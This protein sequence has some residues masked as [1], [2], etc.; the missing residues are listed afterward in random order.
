MTNTKKLEKNN[1]EILIKKDWIIND[2][3]QI[4]NNE[5]AVYIALRA[6]SDISFSE[7]TTT[8]QGLYFALARNFNSYNSRVAAF[9]KEGVAEFNKKHSDVVYASSIDK[10]L[11]FSPDALTVDDKKDHYFSVDLKD[12]TEIVN[13]GG[14]IKWELLRYYLILLSTIMIKHKVPLGKSG[15]VKN[16]VGFLPIKRLANMLGTST[17]TVER[18]NSVLEGKSGSLSRPL[19][20]INRDYLVCQNEDGCKFYA[21]N[22]YGKYANKKYIDICAKNKYADKCIVRNRDFLNY[23]NALLQKYNNILKD[24]YENYTEEEIKEVYIFILRK[25]EQVSQEEQDEQFRD[26]KVFEKFEFLND[27]QTIS[28][29]CW[30]E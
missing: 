11:L 21:N 23:N 29:A 4:S 19:I 27:V 3:E 13:N 30:G 7:Q 28:N 25:N 22:V 18:Y 5:I 17:R 2:N 24:N 12:I 1:K 9:F 16:V 20:Y 14:K 10:Q 8:V 6:S 26:I 15:F